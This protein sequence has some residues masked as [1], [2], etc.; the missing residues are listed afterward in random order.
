[1]IKLLTKQTHISVN[2][3]QQRQTDY[4]VDYCATNVTTR[5]VI[6]LD[7]IYKEK[8]RLHALEAQREFA[9]TAP[10][11]AGKKIDPVPTLAQGNGNGKA[12]DESATIGH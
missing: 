6:H 2:F 12:R 7:R 1:M 5:P 3:G 8:A 11:N 10:R 9:Q 4:F